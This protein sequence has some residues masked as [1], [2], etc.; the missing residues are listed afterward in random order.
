MISGVVWILEVLSKRSGGNI[1]PK[2]VWYCPL[3]LLNF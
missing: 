2:K 1:G 3:L